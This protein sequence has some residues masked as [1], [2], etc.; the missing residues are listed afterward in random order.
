MLEIHGLQHIHQ[1]QLCTWNE[2]SLL[3]NMGLLELKDW[4]NGSILEPIFS[5]ATDVLQGPVGLGIHP[6]GWTVCFGLINHFNASIYPFWNK[7]AY[8]VL[9]YDGSW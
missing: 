7:N 4:G 6:T 1:G 3:G 9:L 2:I 5:R 8:P